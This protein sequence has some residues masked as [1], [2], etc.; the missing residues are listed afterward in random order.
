MEETMRPSPD[1]DPGA[2]RTNEI[3][4]DAD[5]ARHDAD[6]A[7]R[8]SGRG[9]EELV[10]KIDSLVPPADQSENEVLADKSRIVGWAGPL[11]ALCSLILLPWTIYLGN[12]LPSRQLSPHYAIAWTGFD[13]ILLIGLATTAYFAMRRSLYLT[14]SAS[15]SATL[16]VVD[17]WFDI[18]TTPGDQVAQSI[19]L[20]A[21]V[22]LP[23]AAVCLWL[24]LH[25]EHIAERRITL[26]L[27]HERLSLRRRPAR[28]PRQR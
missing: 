2:A 24:S 14:V 15:A 11:F 9:P 5:E 28:G 3:R 1:S 17:A 26:L 7:I 4:H 13:V 25:T 27:A 16:L 8:G 21:A 19:V 6:E 10:D 22:E 20:A 12:T 23:L 18:M